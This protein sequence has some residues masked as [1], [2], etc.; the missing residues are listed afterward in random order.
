MKKALV[1]LSVLMTFVS[2]ITIPDFLPGKA[3]YGTLCQANG[4]PENV[5]RF[6]SGYKLT[7]GIALWF[8]VFQTLIVV[9]LAYVTRTNRKSA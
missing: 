6:V 2:F 7:L 8:M 4:L 1:V 5:E 3:S 9:A